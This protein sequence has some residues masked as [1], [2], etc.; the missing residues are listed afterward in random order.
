MVNPTLRFK[1]DNGNDYPDWEERKIGEYCDCLDS[2]RKPIS[3]S[4]RVKGKYPYYGSTNIQDYIDGYLFDEPLVLLAEDA[5]PFNDYQNQ[6]IA[7]YAEGKFWVN[8]HA[9]VLRSQGNQRFLFY[10]LVHK[11]IRRFVNNQVRG[12]LN[13][14]DM[15]KIPVPVPSLPEQ[16]KIASFLSSIDEKINLTDKKLGLLKQYKQGVMQQIFNQEIRFKDDNGNDYPDWME[17]KLNECASFH[18]GLTYTPSDVADSGT[19]VMRSSNIQKGRIDY[20][21]NVYVRLPI[22]DKLKLK[23]N[24]TL[25]CVRNGS[26]ALV[27]KTALIHSEDTENAT[28][29]AFMMIVRSNDGGRFIYHYLNSELFRKQMFKDFGTGTI[30]QITNGMLNGCKLSIPSLPEQ[31]KIASFLS[32]IDEKINLID[33]QLENLKQYKKSLL[34]QMF[35]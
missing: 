23:E 18:Q 21:D 1:D 12:K 30:N 5:G 15:N 28:W 35:V 24:D 26:K 22:P 9:H 19:L 3:Q 29:G 34:Q 4:E 16:Q 31:Q 13:Q 32:S 20:A 33:T 25:I 7:Q 10:S 8:N 17:K 11:D 27:G 6:P 14:D 2:Q